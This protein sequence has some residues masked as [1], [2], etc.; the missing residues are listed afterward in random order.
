MTADLVVA[1]NRG[2]AGDETTE[3]GRCVGR[4][5]G[6]GLANVLA[7]ALAGRTA[8]WLSTSIDGTRIR[9]QN[10]GG[11][12]HREVDLEEHQ[13]NR[14]YQNVANR[15]LWFLLHRL[16]H[17][18]ELDGFD[19]G[20]RADWRA[21]TEVNARFAAV[22][23]EEAA[24]GATVLTQ[25]YHLALVPALLRARRPDVR[26]AH[27]TAC[28][29]VD[30]E[31]FSILPWAAR[32]D[33]L[34]GMLSADL[35]GFTV[36]RWCANFVACCAAAGYPVETAPH[37]VRASD[38]RWVPVR[39]FPVGVDA[40]ALR[41]QAAADEV[42]QRCATLRRRVG[43]SR[44]IVRVERLDPAKNILRGLAGYELLLAGDSG[45]HGTLT[46]VVHA[47]PSRSAMPEYRRYA[48]AVEE[49]VDRINRRFGTA[50]WTP[51][52]LQSTDDPAD[53][54]AALRLADVIVVNPVLDGMNLVAKEGPIVAERDPVLILSC[55]A[56]AV[57]ELGM[58][59]LV[60]NPFDIAELAEAMAVALTLDPA[61]RAERA[62]V[63]RDAA[64]ALPPQAWLAAQLQEL[65]ATT[66]GT[67]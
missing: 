19:F 64:A 53:G 46:H 5:A 26:I 36:P 63:L 2:P 15:V 49:R 33:L 42:E 31:Y 8:V 54:L 56:G 34:D 51:C 1:A 32:A 6:G 28:P 45:L 17:V 40:K 16:A 55:M 61:D 35:L 57:D 18:A 11:I 50:V 25:D 58:A 67:Q 27:F 37:A 21:Y 47:Y 4:P 66:A 48:A 24:P 62:A 44:L 30:P 10:T 20:F 43:G 60:V 59:S 13:R 22:C 52:L 65:A 14:H 9:R 7:S 29:W 12:C 23:D 38:G 3:D 41:V 39:A